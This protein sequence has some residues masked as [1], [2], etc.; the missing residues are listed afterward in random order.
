MGSAKVTMV[1]DC[2][3]LEWGLYELKSKTA[4][5]KLYHDTAFT[6]VTLACEG[7][8]RIEAHRA[9][10]GVSSDFFL[11]ILKETSTG[12]SLI[13]L[14]GVTLED[15]QLVKSFVYLGKATV[16]F[17]QYGSFAVVAKRMLG[18]KDGEK[19]GDKD[20]RKDGDKDGDKESGSL[21][22]EA[23]KTQ[24][25]KLVQEYGKDSDKNPCPPAQDLEPNYEKDE[26]SIEA[27][28]DIENLKT[29]VSAKKVRTYKDKTKIYVVCKVCLLNIPKKKIRKHTESVHANS[30]MKYPCTF[31]QCGTVLKN[32]DTFFA[33]IR[34]VHSKEN[35]R[36]MCDQCDFSTKYQGEL[37]RHNRRHTGEMIQCEYCDYSSTKMAVLKQHKESR[38]LN[39]SYTCE[40]CGAVKKT[41]KMLK[42][43]IKIIHD[44]YCFYCELCNHKS[45]SGHNMRVHKERVH[46]K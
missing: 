23:L 22:A 16:R 18:S 31:P 5:Q 7:N 45:T 27:K 13:Y 24:Y 6:D 21:P 42:R 38:H 40:Q 29:K 46:D 32:T 3:V 43:H 35:Q 2:A 15:L 26:F 10:L 20:D 14:E 4:F 34:A 37:K 11:D 33:H 28:T 41:E 12:H 8:G 17:A 30:E 1:E 39:E 25:M 36:I 9:V 19:H 44:G